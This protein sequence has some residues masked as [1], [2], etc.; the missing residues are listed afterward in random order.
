MSTRVK[1]NAS[2][3][4][5]LDKFDSTYK[6]TTAAN[7]TIGKISSTSERALLTKYTIS[8]SSTYRFRKVLGISAAVYINSLTKGTS[9][10]RWVPAKTAYSSTTG[11]FPTYSYDEAATSDYLTDYDS[12]IPG[13]NSDYEYESEF[14]SD[15]FAKYAFTNG[16]LVFMSNPGSVQTAN[17][18]NKPYL[19]VTFSDTNYQLTAKT[20]SPTGGY[21]NESKSQSFNWT[22]Q[23]DD[24]TILGETEFFN[25]SVFK[26][27]WRIGSSGTIYEVVGNR[28]G[29]AVPANTFPSTGTITARFALTDGGGHS[30]YTAW[31]TYTT[32]DAISTCTAVSPNGTIETDTAPVTFK[33]SYSNSTGS[34][35][36][37]ADLRCTNDFG[38]TYYQLATVTGSAKSVNV[39]LSSLPAGAFSWLVR[40]ANAEG[41]WSEWSNYAQFVH[42]AAPATP[43]FSASSVPM[44]TLNWQASGQEAYKITIDGVELPI[45]YGSDS[46]YTVKEPLADGTHTLSV[47]VQGLYGLWSQPAEVTIFVENAP[48]EDIILNGSGGIDA[49]LSWETTEATENFMI[50][51]DG[52]R[53][54]HTDKTRFADRLASGEHEYYVLNILPSGNYSK[55]NSL[56][57]KSGSCTPVIG[58]VH[59]EDYLEL[60]LSSASDSEQRFSYSKTHAAFHV[61]GAVYPIIEMSSFE[62]RYASYAVAF[63]DLTSAKRFEALQGKVCII[64]SRA[65]ECIIGALV[66]MD[67]R[68]ADFYIEYTFT[69]QRVHW[70]DFMDE[71]NT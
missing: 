12:T 65:D 20:L 53:I 28:N 66:Q 21:L 3:S 41:V 15:E 57:L 71:T 33:W 31:Q 47:A 11:Q 35:Q 51:R 49:Q 54:A 63:K 17:A 64:K 25:N 56:V 8:A 43:N 9:F 37:A 62:D 58:D 29:C 10:A 39:D 27:Q 45:M 32:T 1:F 14:N 36:T 59:G 16:I 46:T 61:M 23:D 26:L 42:V 44:T 2:S 55:S 18:T 52:K 67:K 68:A 5:L 34:A 60:N 13:Y 69:V 6:N 38:Q 30:S 19:Y 40:V 50:Y 24:G 7:A 4:I 22:W 48:G 70:E